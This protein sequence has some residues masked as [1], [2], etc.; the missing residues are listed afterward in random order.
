MWNGVVCQSPSKGQIVQS[1]SA[2]LPVS[3]QSDLTRFLTN[4]AAGSGPLTITFATA[5]FAPLLTNWLIHAARAGEPA[6]L[7]VAFDRG[8]GDAVGHAG[9]PVIRYRAARSLA[10]LWLQRVLFFEYLLDRD[11][12]FI[13]SDLDAVWK[14][15]PRPLCFADS[16][17][18]LVFSQGTNYPSDIWRH[19]GFVLC[20][21]F[22]AVRASPATVDF[23]TAVRDRIALVG[24][25][26]VAVNHLLAE[27]GV[28]WNAD[29]RSG[30]VLQIG[31]Q[32][33][34]TWRRMVIGA[35]EKLDLRI[36]LLPHHLAPRLAGKFPDAYVHHPVGPGNPA[37]KARVLNEIGCWMKSSAP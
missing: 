36:G 34:T 25:D 27:S 13:H 8:V 9:A 2:T 4:R 10:D 18:D 20:C 15:D 17:L 30:N 22:F 24:D 26:Q 7:V 5:D 3:V 6:P 23:F 11:V 21:G 14:R 19:W 12:D 16:S 35:S 28:V 33:F 29:G 31:D 1:S 37:Q 32:S